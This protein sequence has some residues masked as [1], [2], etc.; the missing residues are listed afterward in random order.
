[1]SMKPGATMFPPASS[2]RRP[3]SPS[4]MSETTPSVSA[5]SAVRAG[6]PVPSTTEPPRITM[7]AGMGPPSGRKGATLRI[8]HARRPAHRATTRQ[9]HNQIGGSAPLWRAELHYLMVGLATTLT[10]VSGS[11]EPVGMSPT[12]G[13]DAATAA[14]PD[15]MP[16][17]VFMGL[18]EV[19][20][21]DRPTPRPRPGELLLEVS[22]CGV[23]G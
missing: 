20:V 19:A 8:Q 10:S 16:A 21:K 3:S 23:C 17:A 2:A 11:G 12:A 14:V 15:L 1:M 13:G 7:S 6:A 9:P 22:H 4:P 5:I 18:R